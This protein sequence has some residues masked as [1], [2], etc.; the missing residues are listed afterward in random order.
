MCRRFI[1]LLPFILFIII[2]I[3]S[4]CSTQNYKVPGMQTII[5]NDVNFKYDP[6]TQLSIS[7]FEDINY[8]TEL[9]GKIGNQVIH[10]FGGISYSIYSLKDKHLCYVFLRF[11]ENT[12]I[13]CYVTSVVEYPSESIK[14]DFLGNI[15]NK[16]NPKEILKH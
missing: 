16:D 14:G 9:K 5:D 6:S 1:I 8:L 3:L 7:D 15:L 13:D 2:G 10:E 12:G 4:G 11:S